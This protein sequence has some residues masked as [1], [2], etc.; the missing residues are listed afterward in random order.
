MHIRRASADD[1]DEI[2]SI[3][4]HARQTMRNNG[5]DAQWINGYPSRDLISSDVERGESY[6]VEGDDGLAHGV[7]MF[8][9][10][11]DPSYDVIEDGAWLNDEPYGV[12]HRIGTDGRIR[13]ALAAAVDFALQ[14]TDNVRID[15]H[16]SNA[17]MRH[18]LAKAG[19]RQCGIVYC[20][21]GTARFAFHL[22]K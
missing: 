18:A 15:T 5:N 6:I 13:G 12:I 20:Q 11:D 14:H 10:G 19:F 22:S 9:L 21:D 1:V 8:A 3:Y 4:D 17:A 2:M 16:E 7:F